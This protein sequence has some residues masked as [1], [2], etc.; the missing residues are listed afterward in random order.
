MSEPG[1]PPAA[2]QPRALVPPAFTR[3]SVSTPE[4]GRPRFVLYSPLAAFSSFHARSPWLMFPTAFEELG[5]ASTLVC[6]S[7]SDLPTPPGLSVVTTGIVSTASSARR[8]VRAMMEPL[9]AFREIFRQRPDV[10]MIGP[11]GPALAS[12]LPMIVLYRRFRRGASRTRFI[13]KTDSNLTDYWLGPLASRLMDLFVVASTRVFDVVTLETYCSLD[14]ARRLVGSRTGRLARVPLG[15]PRGAIALRE[16]GS[17]PREPVILCVA[18]VTP[19]KGQEVLLKAFEVL[20]PTFP[21]WTLRFV[22]PTVSAEY[23]AHLVRAAEAPALRGRVTF[24][25]F[26]SQER[27][28]SEY[29]RAAIFCLP[30]LRESAGQ[31]KYEAAASGIPVVTTDVPCARDAEELGWLVAPAGDAKAL[32]AKLAQLMGAEAVRRENAARAMQHLESYEDLARECLR[33]LGTPSPRAP[34]GNRPG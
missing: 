27:I 20:A 33:I 24:L 8:F 29:A 3:G 17:S 14:R 31:V 6:G 19:D 2:V 21:E 32:A 23:F 10:V 34:P 4:S 5:Y 28:D 13:L 26:V 30:T 12:V 11:M 25:G 15:Y 18:R 7:A 22:G 9:F 16:Y 1:S